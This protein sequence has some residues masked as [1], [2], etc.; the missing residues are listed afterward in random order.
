MKNDS[1]RIESLSKQQMIEQGMNVV[2]GVDLGDKHSFVCLIDLDGKVVER[3]KLRTSLAAFER[4][5]GEWAGMRVVLEA[6]CHSNWVY[7]LLQR[8][9]HEPLMADTH[10]LALIT[11]S[12]SKDDRTDAERLAELGLRRPEMLNPVQPPSLETQSDR[13]VLKAREALVEVRT[14]LIN[15][16]RGTLK[17]F[18]VRL[19]AS[20]GAALASKAGPRL[21]H[22]LRETLGP[23]LL[24]IQPA[25]DEIRRYD[26]RI[27]QL[28]EKKYPQT[29]RMRSARGVGPITSL[30]F[31]LHLDNNPQ[32][33]RRSRDAGAR[34]GLRL[35]RRNSGERSPELSITKTG[36]PMLRRLLVQCAQY[37]L[38]PWGEDSTLRRWGLRLAAR[39]GKSA[40]RK[41][42]VAVARK[43]AVLLHVLWQRDV[44][45]DPFYGMK[46]KT[47]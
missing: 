15:S 30:A 18:G 1:K 12:L 37:M 24:V 16:V 26:K 38:G 32:R 7:R 3:K 41:A 8:L 19:P 25:T 40:K 45:F 11:P 46:P 42:V 29:K 4:Y 36:D 28:G 13:T 20:S 23:L 6:G 14:K 17:S 44:D 33:L 10:R 22:E 47:T 39:G 21:P 9:Q 31:V 2:A 43:L 35:K 27:L 34:L 5:F